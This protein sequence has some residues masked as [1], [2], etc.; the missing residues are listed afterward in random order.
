MYCNSKASN[1]RC[2]DR[3]PFFF[4]GKNMID[5]LLCIWLL[6][7]IRRFEIG[8][9]SLPHDADDATE[10]LTRWNTISWFLG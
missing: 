8:L 6:L 10:A 5:F 3:L 9:I 1:E 4:L 7:S 2:H